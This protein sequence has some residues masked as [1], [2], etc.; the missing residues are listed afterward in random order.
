MSQATESIVKHRTE[1]EWKTEVE[2]ME[3]NPTGLDDDHFCVLGEGEP[4]ETH[5]G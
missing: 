3:A 1:A 2:K 5:P 4:R